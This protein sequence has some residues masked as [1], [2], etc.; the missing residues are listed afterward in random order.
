MPIRPATPDDAPAITA[1]Y[2]HHVLTGT[3]TFEEIPPTQADMAAR[4]AKVLDARA[5]WLVSEDE[6]GVTG[7]AYAAQ[8]RDRSA[9][10][11]TAEDSIYIRPDRTG[12]GLG[13]ALLDALIEASRAFGF[14]EILAVIGDSDNAGSIGVHRRFGF[15]DAGVIRNVG[16]KF[17]RWLD[18][19][20]LQLSI[21]D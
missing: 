5:P 6:T 19:V 18:V 3:G 15:T 20:F 2:A 8:F 4:L 17:D 16:Y 7:F 21:G 11:Y 1:I 10:R 14:R 9:Y 12:Q 13:A